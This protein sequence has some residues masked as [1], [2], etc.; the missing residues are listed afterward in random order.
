MSFV[1]LMCGKK[2]NKNYHKFLRPDDCIFIKH[3]WIFEER[4][5]KKQ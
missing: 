2:S 1:C 4:K 3:I 5:V